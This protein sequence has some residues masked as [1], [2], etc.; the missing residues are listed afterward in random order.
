MTPAASA[1]A[2]DATDLEPTQRQGLGREH[3]ADPT[4]IDVE[5]DGAEGVA[6]AVTAG[7]GHARLGQPCS[8]AMMWTTP[9]LPLPTL[10][11]GCHWP[12]CCSIACSTLGQTVDV[13]PRL[14]LGRDDV[15]DRGDRT[16]RIGNGQAAFTQHG[17]G[18]RAMT[19]W[20]IC[21]S[22]N[23]WVCLLGNCRMVCRS[24]TYRTGCR[25]HGMVSLWEAHPNRHTIH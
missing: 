15:I 20:I 11:R 16:L 10:R 6:V 12:W 2:L 21:R 13:G 8:G 17:E 18:L 7:H 23:S 25:D 3:I 9:C 14:V 22:M 1:I 19:S 4:G 24:Q 5:G